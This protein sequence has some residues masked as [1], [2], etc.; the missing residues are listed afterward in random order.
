MFGAILLLLPENRHWSFTAAGDQSLVPQPQILRLPS[1]RGEVGPQG[2]KHRELGREGC[3]S[4][5]P[6]RIRPP[7]MW[8][9]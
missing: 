3:T 8:P 9:K 6:T 7:Q 4:P 5:G 2:T 1:S